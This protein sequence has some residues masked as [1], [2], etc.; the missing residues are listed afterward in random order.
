MANYYD[1][2]LE[3]IKK[4]DEIMDGFDWHKV[5]TTMDHLEWQWVGVNTEGRIPEISDM[6]RVVR[7]LCADAYFGYFEQG[8]KFCSM[9]TG[10]FEVTFL[11]PEEEYD[12]TFEI[13]FVVAS[14]G[15][16]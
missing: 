9:G 6:K 5:K 2:P 12:M 16:Y 15:N 10:G 1:L 14:W 11:P 13:K 8:S 4:A 7:M 3:V